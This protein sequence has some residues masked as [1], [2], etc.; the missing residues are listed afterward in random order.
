MEIEAALERLGVSGPMRPDLASLRKL[1]HAWATVVPYENLDIQLGRPLP[2]APEALADKII[3]RR[4]GGFCYELNHAFAL[5]LGAIGFEVSII[6]GAV[7]RELRGES[8]WRNHMPLLVTADGEQWLT[9]VGLMD[10][11]LLPIRLRPGAHV[12]GRMTYSLEYLDDEVWRLHHR[13]DGAFTTCDLRSRPLAIEDFTEACDWRATAPES[14]FVQTL[15]V[16][17]TA[18]DEAAILRSRTLTRTGP[19]IPGGK[20]HRVLAD[21]DEFAAVL[22]EEFTLPLTDLDVPALWDRA[23]H[24]HEQWLA[25]RSIGS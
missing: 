17:R 12:E 22:A 15:L 9:D 4:R 14:M 6:E 21:A 3:S 25:D 11:F 23:L 19:A 1:H 18:V 20:Q 13:P 24:Q 8:A 16:A 2:L 10:G 5:L 7:D